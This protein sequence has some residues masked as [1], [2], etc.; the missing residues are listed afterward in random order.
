MEYGCLCLTHVLLPLQISA[1]SLGGQT[2]LLG[3]LAAAPV[4]ANT[5]SSMQGITSQILTNAQGQV[6]QARNP[7]PNPALPPTKQGGT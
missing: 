4:I 6:G 1:A 2:Q 5:I 3:S 7:V